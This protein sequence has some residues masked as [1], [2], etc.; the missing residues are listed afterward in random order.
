VKATSGD[1]T[2]ESG[3]KEPAVVLAP[4]DEEPKLKVHIDQDVKVDETGGEVKHTKVELEIPLAGVLPSPEDAARMVADAKEMVKAA[5]ENVAAAGGPS[6]TKKSKRKA[7]DLNDKENTDSA[8]TP[9]QPQAKKVKTEVELRKEK[10]RTRAFIG[11]GATIA[12]G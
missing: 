1:V 10:I 3:V 6:T 4:V 2:V 12:V 7:E 9:E 8:S 5:T 11:I